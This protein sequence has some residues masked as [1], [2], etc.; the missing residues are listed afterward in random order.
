MVAE[1]NRGT[2]AIDVVR[3]G[4]VQIVKC[5]KKQLAAVDRELEQ[6]R[7]RKSGHSVNIAS[8]G[9]IKPARQNRAILHSKGVAPRPFFSE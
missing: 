4:I 9:A 2:H 3:R 1:G 8:G 5:L 7:S 6:M